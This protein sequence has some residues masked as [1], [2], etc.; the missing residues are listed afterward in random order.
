M[1]SR[2]K[3]AFNQPV[4]AGSQCY[5]GLNA[6][7]GKPLGSVGSVCDVK[8]IICKE[9]TIHSLVIAKRDSWT[10]YFFNACFFNAKL[11]RNTDLGSRLGETKRIE[12]SAALWKRDLWCVRCTVPEWTKILFG[13]TLTPNHIIHLIFFIL[14]HQKTYIQTFDMH[15]LYSPGMFCLTLAVIFMALH[16]TCW[17]YV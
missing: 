7:N 13:V 3:C 16:W 2:L 17:G 6:K 5:L 12:M 11:K 4:Y 14:H 9:T 10:A 8:L 1:F 15:I